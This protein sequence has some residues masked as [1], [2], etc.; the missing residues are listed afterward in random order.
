MSLSQKFTV[1]FNKDD[2]SNNQFLDNAQTPPA[3]DF[4]Q[5][6]AFGMWA[7]RQEMDNSLKYVQKLRQEH[8][9]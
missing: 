3:I 5:L 7:D 8:W 1:V 9:G 4:S 6:P 2:K